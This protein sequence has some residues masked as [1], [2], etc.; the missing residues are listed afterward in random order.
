MDAVASLGD[1][2]MLN[3]KSISLRSLHLIESSPVI[4]T[5]PEVAR[6]YPGSA[7]TDRFFNYRVLVWEMS[8]QILSR[9][10][11]Q[12]GKQG[13]NTPGDWKA[14]YGED[15]PEEALGMVTG[16]A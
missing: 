14:V 6:Y 1:E 12:T 8:V 9:L 3:W 2:S 15:E 11:L 10:R 16:H 5:G 4:T 13:K 7:E